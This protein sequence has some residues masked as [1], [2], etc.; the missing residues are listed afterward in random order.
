MHK[1][2][3]E[4]KICCHAVNI[5]KA[6]DIVSGIAVASKEQAQGIE[7]V[8]RSVSQMDKAFQQNAV[9]ERNLLGLLC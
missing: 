5:T 1:T 6:F 8:N 9:K 7:L 2:G 3:S 4:M